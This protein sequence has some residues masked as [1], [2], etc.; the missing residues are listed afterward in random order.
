MPA[1]VSST[2][3]ATLES[4]LLAIARGTTWL[5]IALTTTSAATATTVATTTSRTSRLLRLP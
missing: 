4:A 2:I 5:L 1:S 3:L